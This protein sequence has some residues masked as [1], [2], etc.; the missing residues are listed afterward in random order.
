MRSFLIMA[1]IMVSFAAL[2]AETKPDDKPVRSE[3]NDDITVINGQKFYSMRNAR[4]F[5]GMKKPMPLTNKTEGHKPLIAN[6]DHFPS[7]APAENAASKAMADSA[8][9]NMP[10]RSE[11]IR[12]PQDLATKSTATTTATTL[13]PANK[14]AT[15]T[16]TKSPVLDIFAPE[17][18]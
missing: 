12:L 7:P 18:N 2:G 3:K 9:A 17:G 1:L 4:R 16:A 8:N 11:D 14:P 13:P 5:S 10:K 15:P 6:H